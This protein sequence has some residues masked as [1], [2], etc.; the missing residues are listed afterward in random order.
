MSSDFSVQ[1]FGFFWSP[2]LQLWN[3]FI[4]SEEN[5]MFDAERR[6][7]HSQIEFGNEQRAIDFDVYSF[8]PVLFI[9]KR[10]DSY[11]RRIL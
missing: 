5:F 2:T 3:N 1:R 8:C 9:F 10:V 6:G 11:V 4:R 7:M